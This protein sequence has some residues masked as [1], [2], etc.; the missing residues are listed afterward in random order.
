MFTHNEFWKFASANVRIKS[1]LRDVGV[2]QCSRRKVSK[3]Y[4]HFSNKAGCVLDR[5]RLGRTTKDFLSNSLCP[6]V[7]ETRS[8]RT[9]RTTQLGSLLQHS[10]ISRYLNV[11]P[12]L[13]GRVAIERRG[14]GPSPQLALHPSVNAR[15]FELLLLCR[16]C[17][18]N[19]FSKNSIYL[20]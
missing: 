17:C 10:Q 14:W 16:S 18:C 8:Q 19:R 9:E 11:L 6:Y 13:E 12:M 20:L 7:V 3:V 2:V 4:A 5:N 15:D 1:S